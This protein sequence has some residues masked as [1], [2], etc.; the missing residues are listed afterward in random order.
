MM[1]I[2]NLTG[3]KDNLQHIAGLVIGTFS[4]H[5]YTKEDRGTKWFS[6]VAVTLAQQGVYQWFP[7]KMLI[8]EK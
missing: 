6:T 4:K 1:I 7:Y 5:R 8:V 2:L 3:I